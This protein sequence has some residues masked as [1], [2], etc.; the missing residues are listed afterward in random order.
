MVIHVKV[1]GP[2]F[3]GYSKMAVIDGTRFT[4]RPRPSMRIL[5]SNKVTCAELG[6]ETIFSKK[7]SSSQRERKELSR[8]KKSIKLWPDAQLHGCYFLREGEI[9]CGAPSRHHPNTVA[10]TV[11]V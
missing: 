10:A 9:K 2:R 8:P 7:E 3:S 6:K 11:T 1:D 5:T 4:I